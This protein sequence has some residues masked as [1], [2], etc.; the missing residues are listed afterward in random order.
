MRIAFVVN[1][2]DSLDPGNSTLRL[3]MEAS[4]SGHSVWVVPSSLFRLDEA[5]RIQASGVQADQKRCRST[6]IF[7]GNLKKSFDQLDDITISDFE[8]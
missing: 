7:L 6:K 3:A 5:D 1:N 2:L 8:V 4:N